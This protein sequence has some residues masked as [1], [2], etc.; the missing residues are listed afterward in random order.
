MIIFDVDG[1]LVD[2]R[3]SFHRSTI[4]TIHHFTGKT[5]SIAGIQKWKS[6]GGYNDDWKLTTAWI[7]ELGVRVT[8]DI[9]K[10]QF[11]KFYWGDGRLG[12]VSRE[13]W[14][15]TPGRLLRWSRRYELSL[16]TGRTRQ[17]LSHTLARSRAGNFFREIVTMDDIDRLKPH[18]DG[19]LRILDGRD[20][21][22]AVYLGDNVDDAIAARRAKVNF[23]GVLP[24]NSTARRLQ[25][26]ALRREGAQT[27]LHS[28]SEL[29]AWLKRNTQ[30]KSRTRIV[31][32]GTTEP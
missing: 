1:V 11:M 32:R 9:V 3:G 19:L 6:K 5:V 21:S 10:E 30:M 14:L 8:H 16:F 25:G 12:N 15:V 17:E 20:P 24:R 13:R 2:V 31:H 7:R 27:I 22:L 26:A 4:Q 28:V 23:L 18:P 29:D